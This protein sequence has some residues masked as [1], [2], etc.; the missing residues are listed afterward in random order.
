L[1]NE[2]IEPGAVPNPNYSNM[3]KKLKS[4][5]N[6]TTKIPSNVIP[7]ITGNKVP[8][9]WCREENGTLYVF[10]PNPNADKIKFPLEYGQA[11]ETETK[12]LNVE[13]NYTNKKYKLNLVFEPYQSLLFK[14]EHGKI[15][16]LNIEFVPKSPMVKKRSDNYVA[17][18]LVK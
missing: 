8:R 3:V 6:V 12:L 9:H 2:P 11:F 1:K 4:L 7:F 16:Q 13:I 15:S 14:I 18:W 17:P 10:F 5:K